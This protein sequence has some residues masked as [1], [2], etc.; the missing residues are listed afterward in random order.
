M[1]HLCAI[2]LKPGGLDLSLRTV[3]GGKPSQIWLDAINDLLDSEVKTLLIKFPLAAIHDDTNIIFPVV[4][5]DAINPILLSDLKDDDGEV[6]TGDAMAWAIAKL[7]VNPDRPAIHGMLSQF[8]ELFKHPSY[9]LYCNGYEDEEIFRSDIDYVSGMIER[10]GMTEALTQ[11][12]AL[13]DNMAHGE[14]KSVMVDL[15]RSFGA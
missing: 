1:D 10:A 13:T 11:W 15:I 6:L 12:K 7:M 9:R 2:Y 3:V 14:S 4:L 5:H 8:K